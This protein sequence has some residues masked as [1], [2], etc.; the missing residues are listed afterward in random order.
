MRAGQDTRIRLVYLQP[1]HVDSGVGRYLYP[2]EEGGVDEEKLSFWTANEKVSER[3]SFKLK[4][5]SA[6]P[7]DALRAPNHP[8]A[9]ISRQS[10]GEWDLVIDNSTQNQTTTPK[11]EAK[12]PAAAT[13]GQ[14]VYTL[15]KDIAVYWRQADNLPGAVELIAHKP[16][17]A[18][19][20]TFMMVV[21]PGDD[22]QPITE[23]GD[24][25]FVLDISGSMN[26]KYSAL[27]EG[28]EKALSAMR[29][30]DRFR[31]VLFNNRAQEMTNGYVTATAENVARYIEKVAKVQPDNGTNLYSGLKMGMSGI[32]A[33]RT[34]S[35]VL[36]TD[37]VA[38][39]G[40]TE[41][42]KFLKLVDNRDIRLFTFIMGNS[43]NRPMLEAITKASNGFYLSVSNSDDIV[44]Q[45][46]LAKSK[47]TH[48]ALH[49]VEID[50]K[51]IKVTEMTP[52]RI[53]SL[54]RGQQLVL[55]G[56]YWGDGEADVTLSGKI[57]GSKTT[58]QT[59]FAFP[60][61]SSENPELERLWAYAT[62]E[63]LTSEMNNFGEKADLKQ[64]VTDLGV[65][66]GLVTDYTSMLVVRDEVFAQ[67]GIERRNKKRLAVEEAAHQQRVTRPAQNRRVDSAQPMY[68]NNR[69][70]TRRSSGGGA[71]DPIGLII[72][73]GIPAL[74]LIRRRG[75][76]E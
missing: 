45:I 33:D 4:V 28:V 37:G 68:S 41:Q 60:K 12:A 62:I 71:I 39:V 73:A 72:L 3:F 5:K 18:K 53:G 61:S 43:N 48:Q 8:Q 23:G 6:W 22:L 26:G 56:H 14:P 59:R 75:N 40:E 46:L 29:P 2:L 17:G 16:A 13:S 58:Y 35:I 66:Y 69:T 15:D 67:R 19:K 74:L 21:T 47:V 31:I 1:A 20:G 25:T 52:Q 32:E 9:A 50:I 57:S 64:A 11:E 36:V 34:S 24:W 7:V 65:E 63:H 27:A 54:Y 30:N 51:G 76:E 10:D 55:L 42:R 49:D 44:G 70:T 38:N